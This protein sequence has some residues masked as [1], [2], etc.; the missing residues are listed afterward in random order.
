LPLERKAKMNR[1][2]KLYAGMIL[3]LVLSGCSSLKVTSDVDSSYD[4]STVKTF[5]YFGWEQ[6]SDKIL[7]GLDRE[8]IE[9]AFGKEFRDRG[10]N[11]VK[12]D[13]DIVVALYIVTEQKTKTRATT[14]G[15]SSSYGGYGYG[16]YYGYGPGWGWGGG[17]A[18][19][20]YRDIDYTEGTLVVSV[21]DAKLKRLIWNS[22][23]SDT[24]GSGNGSREENIQKVVKAIMDKYPIKAP[25]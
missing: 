11:L 5:E 10:M 22:A 25:K 19:T 8:R 16:G 1:L 9:M 13:G 14:T 18:T 4:F 2:T 6:D 20:T 23:G 3:L 12:S 24:I 7:N 15:M 21:F 17:M